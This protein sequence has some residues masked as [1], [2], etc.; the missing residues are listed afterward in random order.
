MNVPFSPRLQPSQTSSYSCML[1]TSPPV[2]GRS[3]DTY[4]PPHMQAHMNSQSMTTSGTTSTGRQH[5]YAFLKNKQQGQKLEMLGVKKKTSITPSIQD[6]RMGIF[7]VFVKSNR[8][9]TDTH[10]HTNTQVMT[11]THENVEERTWSL[12]M[13]IV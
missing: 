6:V 7:I 3:Y 10:T 4:T 12:T 8:I 9:L 11:L 2:N 1:P 13:N 5:I